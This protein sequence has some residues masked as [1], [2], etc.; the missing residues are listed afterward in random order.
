MYRLAGARFTL[1]V[2][3]GVMEQVLA[4]GEQ[5]EPAT[6]LLQ[7]ALRPARLP[8][9]GR[10]ITA[11]IEAMGSAGLDGGAIAARLSRYDEA[12]VA[13]RLDGNSVAVFARM[14]LGKSAA[15]LPIRLRRASLW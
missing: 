8:K 1:A 7:M 15:S 11:A 4:P 3:E 14:R 13:A 2:G 5:Q 9:L 12:A 6:E 10:L